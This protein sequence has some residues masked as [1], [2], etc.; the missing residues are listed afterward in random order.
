VVAAFLAIATFLGNESVKEAIQ[1][2]TRASD[3]H[4]QQ[5][6]YDTQSELFSTDE[7]MVG[8]FALSGTPQQAK[9]A[10]SQID[11]F[12]K[13]SKS[14]APA[15]AHFAEIVKEKNKEVSD[16]NDKHLLYELAEVLL[17]IAIVLASVSIIAKRRL[18]LRGGHV[19]AAVGVVILV[20]GYVS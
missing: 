13:A 9:V 8:L 14:L 18:L 19:I 4:V 6:T 5:T 1:A 16:Q 7:T 3:A 12:T 15:T 10:Q 17:Q 20:V 11:T 2:Q